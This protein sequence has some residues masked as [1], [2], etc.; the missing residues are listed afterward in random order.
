M[1]DIKNVYISP[2]RRWR[3]TS[4]YYRQLYS[5]YIGKLYSS[6]WFTLLRGFEHGRTWIQHKEQGVASCSLYNP[7]DILNYRVLH[8]NFREQSRV[9][10]WSW[11]IEIRHYISLISN[12][13]VQHGQ[14][15]ITI[16]QVGSTKRGNQPLQGRSLDFKSH[17]NHRKTGLVQWKSVQCSNHRVETKFFADV[18]DSVPTNEQT[19]CTSVRQSRAVQRATERET[20]RALCHWI[21]R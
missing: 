9:V 8:A 3:E 4:E 19:R 10:R 13:T 6:Y 1:P 16:H 17:Q 11:T 21:H 15:C 2:L 14:E 5:L 12:I 18:S 7:R 20:K